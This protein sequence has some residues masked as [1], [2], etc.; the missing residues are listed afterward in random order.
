M[1]INAYQINSNIKRDLA[2]NSAVVEPKA[3]E[4]TAVEQIP[5]KINEKALTKKFSLPVL[6][7]TIAGT[8]IPIL[9]IKKHQ[10]KNAEQVLSKV[11]DFKSRMKAIY[12]PLNI[13]YKLKEMLS[14]SAGSILGGL[15]GGFLFD[16]N[17]DKENNKSKIKEAVFQLLNVSIPI[18]IGEQAVKFTKKKK[19]NGALPQLASAVI[20]VGAGM[21]IAAK[22]SNT[23]NNKVIDKE[24]PDN[25]KLKIKDCFV[26][27]DDFIGVFVLSGIPL[28]KKLQVEKIL[29]FL[30]GMCGYEAGTK[31]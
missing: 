29:P 18:I 10:G 31:K 16:K 24:N 28:A 21:P 11:V 19:L 1:N 23:I 14:V 22:I 27:I 6:L 9:V 4:K 13:T 5:Q 30:Y 12:E 15:T 7:T 17:K 8:I 25:R 20:A 2:F 3:Q 26:H